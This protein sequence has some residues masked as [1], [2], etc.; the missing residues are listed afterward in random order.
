M[1]F[2]FL[3]KK[4]MPMDFAQISISITVMFGLDPDIYSFS[5]SHSLA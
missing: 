1:I 4:V 2:I 3:S 5:Y